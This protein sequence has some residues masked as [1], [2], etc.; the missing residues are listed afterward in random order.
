MPL[1]GFWECAGKISGVPRPVAVGLHSLPPSLSPAS[2]RFP[3][4]QDRSQGPAVPMGCVCTR[5]PSRDASRI[6]LGDSPT[7]ARPLPVLCLVAQSCPT[8]CDPVDCSP[9]RSSVH[10]DS[11]G[12]NTGVGC[13]FLLQG[14]LLTQG[15]NPCL[16]CFLQ[17]Q[18]CSLPLKVKVK[19]LSWV[20]LFALP[21]IAA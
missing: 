10:G 14:I 18:A 1:S 6:G 8:V 21:W 4:A 12:N 17:W 7:G 16:L 13:H 19:S 20:R 5:S 3:I 9:P 15:L 2:F 11:P